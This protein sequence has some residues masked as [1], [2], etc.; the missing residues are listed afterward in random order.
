M[1]HF[2]SNNADVSATA[3][4]TTLTAELSKYFATNLASNDD[5]TGEI[6]EGLRTTALPAA[7]APIT[8]SR[9]NT[10][11]QQTTV[12]STFIFYDNDRESKV[13]SVD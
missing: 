1:S 4:S 8:G 11:R 3:P 10:D 2:C 9:D 7:I 5:E 12:I 13:L 6:S